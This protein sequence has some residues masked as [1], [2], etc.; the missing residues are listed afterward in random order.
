MFDLQIFLFLYDRNASSLLC[1][2]K[3]CVPPSP[4]PSSMIDEEKYEASIRCIRNPPACK[5]G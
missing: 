2:F 3:R 4:N 5:C 1:S